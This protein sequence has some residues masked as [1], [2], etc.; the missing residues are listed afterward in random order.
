MAGTTVET[1]AAGLVGGEAGAAGEGPAS[2]PTSRRDHGEARPA[3]A[4]RSGEARAETSF[5]I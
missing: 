3:S 1:L 2:V 5:R 4:E